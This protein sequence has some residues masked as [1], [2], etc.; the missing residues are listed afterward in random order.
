ML[1]KNKV[2]LF[3]IDY[4]LFN[5]QKA[6]KQVYKR[7]QALMPQYTLE[8]VEEIASRVYDAIR[9]ERVF[10]TYLFTEHFLQFVTSDVPFKTLLDIWW[11]KDLLSSALYPETEETLR[12][13]QERKKYILGIFSTGGKLQRAKIQ[14]IGDFFKEEH[15]HIH[16]LKDDHLEEI[17]D[18]YKGKNI[19]LVDDY[20]PVLAKGKLL[21]PELVTIWIKRGRVAEKFLPTE[22]FTPDY[23][24]TA[25]DEILRIIP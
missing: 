19:Y 17:F 2:V 13:L 6:R 22:D 24:I 12:T 8:Q 10:N 14:A 5:T 16:M 1:M 21:N 9:K 18:K 11:D 7:I 15:I 20:I 3:D 25:L 23:T 4:T